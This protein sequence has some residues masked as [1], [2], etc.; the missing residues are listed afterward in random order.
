MTMYA[1]N[2]RKSWLRGGLLGSARR[3]PASLFRSIF[4]HIPQD[5]G[6]GTELLRL[7]FSLS[8][9]DRRGTWDAQAGDGRADQ[10][11]GG[12]AL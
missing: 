9:S 4:T 2:E 1:R 6:A 11:A 7:C 3:R 5:T 12:W 8:S 10:L